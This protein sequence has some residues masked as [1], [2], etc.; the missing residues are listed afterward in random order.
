VAQLLD[1]RQPDVMKN[2]QFK[3]I[4]AAVIV[5]LVSWSCYA[6]VYSQD[7][8]SF[9]VDSSKVTYVE[10]CGWSVGSPPFYFGLHEYGYSMDVTGKIINPRTRVYIV[11]ATFTVP[12]RPQAAA[13]FCGFILVVGLTLANS[14]WRYFR[15]RRYEIQVA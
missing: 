14:G 1:V 2:G 8:G 10:K 11:T 3:V 5:F 12:L 7:V 9:F 4:S 6:Q 13:V 15:R